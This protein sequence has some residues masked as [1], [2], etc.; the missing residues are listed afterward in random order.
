MSHPTREALIEAGLRL[1]ENH[2]LAGMSVNDVVAEAEVA[3]GTFYVHFR[4]RTAY[5]VSLHQ[6]F[7]DRLK[8]SVLAATADL[9]HGAER[10]R[11]G[12]T[13]YLDG[14]LQGKA[15]KALLLDARSEPAISAEVQRRNADFAGLAQ[16]DFEAMGRPHAETSARLYVVMGAEAAL[17]E[18][19]VG[20]ASNE[21]RAALFQFIEC[22]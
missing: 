7:H 8:E 1:A 15:V 22:G 5:L 16:E 13:A 18:L 11:R 12:T 6:W 10:L 20:K 4:D 19:E 17:M 21:V 9:P 3:K 2:G 14:C